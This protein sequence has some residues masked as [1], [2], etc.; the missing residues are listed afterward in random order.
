MYADADMSARTIAWAMA[1]SHF[2]VLRRL[3]YGCRSAE[4]DDV[5]SLQ[6]E[7][8]PGGVEGGNLSGGR[9]RRRVFPRC[10]VDVEESFGTK[11]QPHR[12]ST[13]TKEIKDSAD[14]KSSPSSLLES[15]QFLKSGDGCHVVA[16]LTNKAA[17][18]PRAACNQPAAAII[19]LLLL[20][21]VFFFF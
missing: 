21:V 7:G 2:V 4:A 14:P 1:R 13:E 6:I 10:D 5:S 12:P 9:P 3:R 19:L 20:R 18:T 16:R 15:Q 17:L 11:S 8:E